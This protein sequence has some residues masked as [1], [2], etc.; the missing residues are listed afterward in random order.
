MNPG[1]G[2]EKYIIDLLFYFTLL[3][4]IYGATIIIYSS[5]AAFYYFIK[6]PGTD[7]RSD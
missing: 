4:E 6:Q 5:S 2:V 7:K 1:I 3:L